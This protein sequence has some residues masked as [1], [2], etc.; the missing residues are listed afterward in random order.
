[1]V[2]GFRKDSD[3]DSAGSS[4]GKPP[5][6]RTPRLTS[7]TLL[8]KCMWQGWASDQVL[9]IAMTGRPFH[10][11]GAYP[12][13]MARER[14]PKARRSSGANQRALR[15]FSGVF[16]LS[17]MRPPV[18]DY[19]ESSHRRC[20]ASKAWCSLSEVRV[21]PR[22]THFSRTSESHEHQQ[23]YDSSAAFLFD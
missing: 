9:R 3:S 7:S 18:R 22:A 4:I 11:S 14:W 23:T 15:S 13:C 20:I 12:I 8:L 10:S 6:I 19:R 2:V 1:M 21:T 16:L 17:V 5:A